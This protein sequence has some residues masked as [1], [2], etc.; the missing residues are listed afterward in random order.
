MEDKGRCHKERLWK[1][2]ACAEWPIVFE[3]VVCVHYLCDAESFRALVR[4]VGGGDV[5]L[6]AEIGWV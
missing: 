1:K 2:F 4:K 5:D 3:V 6:G